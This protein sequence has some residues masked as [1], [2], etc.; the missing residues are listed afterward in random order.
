VP[1]PTADVYRPRNPQS[2]DYYSYVEDYFET[3]SESMK[4]ISSRLYGF[5]RPYVHHV[6]Y[7]YL[8]CGNL[9][10]RLSGFNKIV[11]YG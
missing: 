11:D 5:W 6:I 1:P 2:S 7:R 4:N 9:H 10:N 8:D 3:L